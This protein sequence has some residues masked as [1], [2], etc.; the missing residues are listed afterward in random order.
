[1]AGTK[2]AD[3]LDAARA[4]PAHEV[5]RPTGL[6][7]RVRLA[8]GAADARSRSRPPRPTTRCA[9]SGSTPNNGTA[10]YD[11]LQLSALARSRTQHGR[12]RVV[13]LLT[14]G[15]DVSSQASLQDAL[16]T[17]HDTATLVYPIA[18]GGD[19]A[20]VAPLQQ[21]ASV[22]GGSFKSAAVQRDALE[23]GLLVDRERAQ[24]HLA[25]RVRHRRPA[26]R[27]APPARGAEP[28]RRRL[29]ERRAFPATPVRDAGGSALPSPL[30]SPLGGL[31]LTMLVAFLVLTACGFLFASAKGSWVKTRLAPHVE[32]LA[33]D[34]EAP[35][36]R[37]PRRARPGSSARPSRRSATAASGTSCSG[38]SSGPTCRCARSSSPT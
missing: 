32:G 36:G 18:I 2:L 14:D 17:A 5:A 31:L 9:C 33:Q 29:D 10:L 30:Y 6:R 37:A 7:G 24:A 28:G 27:A 35:E 8:G 1:M 23:R 34:A 4:V 3:A 19:G 21:M 11:A 38:S 22:T 13:V 12:A 26:G 16:A 15:K 25:R 20:T